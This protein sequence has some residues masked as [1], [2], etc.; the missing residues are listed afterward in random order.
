MKKE[1]NTRKECKRLVNEFE[2]GVESRK[3]ENTAG[4]RCMA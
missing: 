4:Q 3:R 1:E 2:M